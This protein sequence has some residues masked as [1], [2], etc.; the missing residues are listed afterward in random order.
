[1]FRT[2]LKAG[3]VA[4]V[5]L[6]AEQQQIPRPDA[7]LVEVFVEML[8]KEIRRPRLEYATMNQLIWEIQSRMQQYDLVDKKRDDD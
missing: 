6:K 5:F 2:R 3:L 4:Q 1:M 8:E 7:R